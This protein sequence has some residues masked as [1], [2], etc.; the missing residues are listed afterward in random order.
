MIN[1]SDYFDHIYS[2]GYVKRDQTNFFNE[3]DRIGIKNSGIWSHEYSLS[4]PL[5]DKLYQKLTDS[6]DGEHN[7]AF[8]VTMSHLKVIKEAYELG[9]ERIF[10]IEDDSIFRKNIDEIENLMNNIPDDY[11]LVWLNWTMC[12]YRDWMVTKYNDFYNSIKILG[13]GLI[14]YT[15][16][17][18]SSY[19]IDRVMMEKIIAY[20]ENNYSTDPIDL[21]F[22]KINIE[23][24]NIHSLKFYTAEK[25]IS[26][27]VHRNENGHITSTNFWLEYENVYHHNDSLESFL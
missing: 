20:Y 5:M 10:I 7:Y 23:D 12:Q 3:L 6:P 15:L 25:Q 8:D 26:I 1:W 4:G 19:C 11:S 22:L 13:D 16:F 9:Y 14:F 2:I 17:S 18:A 24:Q 21:V 27:Q